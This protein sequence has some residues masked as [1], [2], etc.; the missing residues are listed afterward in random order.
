MMNEAP[1]ILPEEATYVLSESN[2]VAV[3]VDPSKAE[4]MEIIQTQARVSNMESLDEVIQ[5]EISREPLGY[6]LAVGTDSRLRVSSERPALLLL[7]SGTSGP[8]KMVVHT[9]RFFYAQPELCGDST[10]VFLFHRPV[11]WHG[12][13]RILIT[14]VLAGV[15]TEILGYRSAADVIWERLRQG[16]ITMMC[17]QVSLLTKMMKE[18]EEKLCHPP[19]GEVQVYHYMM[20]KIRHIQCSGCLVPVPLKKFWRRLLTGASLNSVYAATELGTACLGFDIDCAEAAEVSQIG[21]LDDC[22]QSICY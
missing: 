4:L 12:G 8:P 13:I 15:R 3:L 19:A 17:L 20:S 22:L 1:E 11:F 6:P 2:A 7:T 9:R 10:D 16:D 5:I 18:Y 14:I 21:F